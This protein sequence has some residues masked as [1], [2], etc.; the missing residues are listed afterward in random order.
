MD[1]APVSLAG[2]ERILGNGV[3]D[4]EGH[5]LPP[6]SVSPGTSSVPGW[7]CQR[8]RYPHS[9]AREENSDSMGFLGQRTSEFLGL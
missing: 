5:Y 2:A 9:H 3:Q 8:T 4:E 6:L 1:S 7:Y